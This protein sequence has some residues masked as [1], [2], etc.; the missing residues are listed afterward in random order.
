[1][2]KLIIIAILVLSF[3]STGCGLAIAGGTQAGEIDFSQLKSMDGLEPEVDINLKGWLMGITQYAIR[4][5]DEEQEN[6]EWMKGLESMRVK[7]FPLRELDSQ[8]IESRTDSILSEMDSLGWETIISIKED[9]EK[10]YVLSLGNENEISGL[11]V[12]VLEH[13]G[14]AVFVN[15]S[16]RIPKEQIAEIIANS[17]ITSDMKI[18]L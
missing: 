8:D 3:M 1:M 18:K 12:I 10:V 11:T 14:E 9:N 7:I 2:K 17:D 13:N 15:F 16:G 5:S 4:H 6:T